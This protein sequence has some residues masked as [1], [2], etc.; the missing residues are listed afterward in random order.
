M[1]RIAYIL[2][3]VFCIALTSHTAHAQ[4]SQPETIPPSQ[5][6]GH[7]IEVPPPKSDD[8]TSDAEDDDEEGMEEDD[9]E[10]PATGAPKEKEEEIIIIQGPR[11]ASATSG[12]P[13]PQMLEQ[14]YKMLWRQISQQYI[15]AYQ[16]ESW[17]EWE[18]KFD[19]K[20]KSFA[21][22]DNAVKQM[23]ESLGDRWT[24]YRGSEDFKYY[25]QQAKEGF[26]DIGLMLFKHKDG[27]YHVDGIDYGSP[28]K[29]SQLREGDLVKSINGKAIEKLSYNEVN[30][31]LSGKPGDKVTLVAV[32]AGADHTIELTFAK[33]EEPGVEIDL[34]PGK[35]GYIRFPTFMSKDVHMEF[36]QGLVKLYQSTKG[37]LNG[38]VLDLRNNGGGR[39]DI[40]I[41]ISSMFVAKG[42]VTKTRVRSDRRITETEYQ[43]ISTPNYLEKQ[44]LPDMAH[45]QHLLQTVPLV[46]LVNGSS[47]SASEITTGALKD[48]LRGHVIG[49]R[50]FGKA[51]GFTRVPLANG[52]M[53]QV[54]NLSYLTPN[55]SDIRHKG[56][57]PNEV[58]ENPRDSEDDLQ[59]KAAHVY[60]MKIVK[61][62]TAQLNKAR[63]LATNNSST[64]VGHNQFR[65]YA[66]YLAVAV[67]TG[68]LLFLF[69][70]RRQRARRRR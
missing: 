30:R 66:L 45:F 5:P 53:I 31:L 58:V 52:G 12:T 35:I 55:G 4:S 62:R 56:I 50:S 67:G 42:T 41:D 28:T 22:L 36:I 1:N 10:N 47:A 60:L 37:E 49:T 65:Q 8:A 21:D 64:T 7:S 13:D 27:A 19:G 23:A 11:M 44:M 68:T 18:H 3:L 9:E 6:P 40:A 14:F 38:L 69:Y 61:V 33:Y 16:L 59:L 70:R 2:M 57:E 15:D 34:L 20:L 26:I 54:T 39:V 63:E 32:W 43:T 29:A 24:I 46:V 25:K 51:V 48:N 17:G